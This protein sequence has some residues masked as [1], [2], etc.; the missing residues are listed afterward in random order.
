M[1]IS[2]PERR[3]LL[4]G[5]VFCSPVVIGLLLFMAY[6]IIASLVY[7]FCRYSVMR[8]PS[9]IGMANYAH[10]THD[11]LFWKS[12]ANT[13]FYA[14]IAVPFGIIVAL[15]LALLLNTKI[16]GLALYRTFFYVPSIVPMVASSV[17]WIWLFNPQSGAIN[18][19]LRP[20]FRGLQLGEPPGWLADPAWSK[21]AIILWSIW[22]IGGAM[23][24]YLAGLQDVPQE[25][26][27][28]A[29]VD[30]AGPWH[31]L[32]QITLPFI[33]PH[34]L[35]TFIMGMIGAFQ[36]FTPAYVMTNGQGGP[37]DSTLFYSLYLFQVAFFDFKMGY[38]CAMAWILFLLILTATLLIFRTSARYVYYAGGERG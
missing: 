20:L 13:G 33:S 38:A 16:R 21:P 37:V 7:S 35:F 29:E 12:L 10:L 8:P 5:L 1:A 11:E 14:I 26:Y 2:G 15:S 17:L 28:A 6:P 31:R 22:G 9:F 30:G 25:L 24:I 23:V 34:L 19:L 36:F 3:R 32:R 27:E 4:R 18:A